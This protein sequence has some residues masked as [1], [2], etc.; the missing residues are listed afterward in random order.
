MTGLSLGAMQGGGSGGAG[1]ATPRPPQSPPATPA[2]PG[3]AGEPIVVTVPTGPRTAD[4]IRTDIQNQIRNGIRYGGNPQINIPPDFNFRN[5]VPYGAVDISIA[6]FI[7]IAVIIVGLP[8]ARALGRRMD[9]DNQERLSGAKTIGPQIQQLQ[10][11]VDAMALELERIS[12]SQR[13][14]SKLMAGKEKEPEP[15]KLVR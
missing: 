10:E 1:G 14:Q 5:A 8:I 12:E 4:Q 7:T 2:T 9:T 15:A 3:S 6:F 11:S 13:F